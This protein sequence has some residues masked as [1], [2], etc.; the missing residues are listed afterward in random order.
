MVIGLVTVS[1]LMIVRAIKKKKQLSP[2]TTD[3]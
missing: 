2:D 3:K 1:I